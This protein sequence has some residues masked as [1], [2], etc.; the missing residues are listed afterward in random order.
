[1]K[2]TMPLCLDCRKDLQAAGYKV[3]QVSEI[4]N[5]ITCG[6]CGKDTYGGAFTVTKGKEKGGKK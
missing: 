2:Q 4:V 3:N 1:M 6:I 5:R